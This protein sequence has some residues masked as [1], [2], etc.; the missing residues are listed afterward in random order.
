MELEFVNHGEKA[1]TL[2]ARMSL[3]ECRP[4][5]RCVLPIVDKMH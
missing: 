2:G 3:E 4:L 5:R 1:N